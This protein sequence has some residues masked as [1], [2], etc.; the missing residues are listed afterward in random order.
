MKRVPVSWF[1]SSRR[2]VAVRPGPDGR[3]TIRNLPAG[4]YFVVATDDIDDNQWFEVST[5]RQLA[6]RAA[7]ISLADYER[8]TFNVAGR[9]RQL[10]HDGLADVDRRVSEH[11]LLTG[12][13]IL[14]KP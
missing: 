12:W 13:Q 5:L 8:K 10:L 2:I 9:V 6:A 7:K 1:P 11:A 4:E 14:I 3:Y